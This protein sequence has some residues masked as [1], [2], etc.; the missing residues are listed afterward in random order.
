[1][2]NQ[3]VI[4]LI[5]LINSQG[6]KCY[7][8]GGFVRD[9]LL[10][11]KNLDIDIEVFNLDLNELALIVSGYNHVVFE[12][13]GVIK[14]VDLN[15]DLS[16]PKLELKNNNKL[17]YYQIKYKF[18]PDLSIKEA[19]LRRDITINSIY[20]DPINNE[21]IDEYQGIKD[22]EAKRFKVLNPN[23]DQDPMRFFRSLVYIVKYDLQLDKEEVESLNN[24]QINKVNNKA[25]SLLDKMM[26]YDH[27]QE[28]LIDVGLYEKIRN[29]I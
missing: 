25:R 3:Q 16:I 4:E 24:M 1:M 10:G 5:T 29:L 26:S 15:V 19:A 23:F 2:I 27:Y 21:Y 22:L 12:Q 18:D 13:Y 11:I 8:V 6:G 14:I 28:K 9:Q 7:I 20:Y 17:D